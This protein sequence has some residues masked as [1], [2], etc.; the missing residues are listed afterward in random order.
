MSQS[1][2]ENP[3]RFKFKAFDQKP[4]CHVVPGKWTEPNVQFPLYQ[5][6]SLTKLISRL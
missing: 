3:H 6:S 1:T 2:V 5:P 4:V